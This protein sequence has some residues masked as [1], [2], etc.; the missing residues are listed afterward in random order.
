V[1][2]RTP[3]ITMPSPP[4]MHFWRGRQTIAPGAYPDEEA[5]FADLALVY[6]AEIADLA[7]RGCRYIQIDEVPLAMLCDP[8]V[9]DRIAANGEDPERLVHRYLALI[10]ACVGDRPAELT[11]GLHLCRGNHKGQW[12]SEGGYDSVA[13]LLFNEAAV[14]AFFLEYDTDRAGGFEP[15][16]HLPANRV[17]VLGLVS[18]KVPELEPV[19]GLA[20]R[21][22]AAARFAPLDNLAISPQCGFSSSLGGN[23]ITTNDQ[24]RKLE[25]VVQ[26]A[27]Q[28]WGSP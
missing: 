18:T 1:T 24:R 13:E 15:L 21:V 4:T 10:N 5:Y 7:A 25:R 14:D 19:D 28:V 9:R 16:R 6:R 26:T 12:L 17:A 3:K 8:Q 2:N 20:R 22:D 11:L 23:P 27:K